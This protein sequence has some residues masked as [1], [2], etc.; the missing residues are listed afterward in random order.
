MKL[1]KTAI[2]F[3]Q[4]LNINCKTLVQNPKCAQKVLTKLKINNRKKGKHVVENAYLSLDLPLTIPNAFNESKCRGG[5]FVIQVTVTD[6]QGRDFESETVLDPLALFDE[7]SK[8]ETYT[9]DESLKVDWKQQKSPK[10]EEE[11][12]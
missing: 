10:I 12:N 5:P 6:K 3:Y 8:V 9:T 4:T 2:L 7:I 11:K 1:F